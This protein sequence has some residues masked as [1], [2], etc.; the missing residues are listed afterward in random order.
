MFSTTF[1]HGTLKK[2]IIYFGTLFNNINVERFDAN[3]AVVQTMKVPLN[4][5]PREKFLARLDGNAD[6]DRSIAIQLPRMTFEMN[7]VSYD[8]TRKLPSINK[9][10]SGNLGPAGEVL[11]QYNPVP[12]NIDFTLSIMVKNAEDGTYIVEQIL[13]YFS[14]SWTA[15]LN[16]NPE[17]GIK[18]DVPIVINGANF[19][20]TYEG[21]FIER[22]AIIWTLG[23]TMKGY[24][25]GPTISANSSIIRDIDVNLRSVPFY[26]NS[27]DATP[28][29]VAPSITIDIKPGQ[30]ANGDPTSAVNG[31]FTYGLTG[32]T[33]PFY[34]T[35]QVYANS[36]NYAYVSE[37]NTT[38]FSA[39]LI[40]GVLTPNTV[41]T[42]G[43]T[44]YTATIT[45]VTRKPEASVNNSIIAA[46]SSYGFLIDFIEN[47]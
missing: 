8:P 24:L 31:L 43:T 34:V 39:R 16:I 22:R 47:L 18:Y 36:N 1:G 17:L 35:E 33:G 6:L 10:R 37:S 21:S 9:V 7:N 25:F 32:A 29:T 44:G 13:P 11:Y 5:G 19:S 26:L 30:F 27:I 14:P 20:D 15:T 23:F 3:N 28:N 45:S 40:E 46:N 42:G 2:Y 4:Y 41:I 38:S 12:Y